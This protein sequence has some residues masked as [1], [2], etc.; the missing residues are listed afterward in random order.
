M[1][2]LKTPDDYAAFNVHAPTPHRPDQILARAVRDQMGDGS[3]FKTAL[4]AVTAKWPAL[5]RAYAM[6]RVVAEKRPKVRGQVADD[7]ADMARLDKVSSGAHLAELALAESSRDASAA[8]A[9]AT[10][11][12]LDENDCN[13]GSVRSLDRARTALRIARPD[14]FAEYAAEQAAAA[15][16]KAAS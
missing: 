13:D 5:W 3:D 7:V 15:S 9:R 11:M 4:A 2:K 8:L 16:P 10:T 1:S 14:L 12:W 6:Y